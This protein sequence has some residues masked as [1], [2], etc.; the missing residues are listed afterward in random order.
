MWIS[1]W[2]SSD[3]ALQWHSCCQ[4]GGSWGPSSYQV[5]P[6]VIGLERVPQGLK[7]STSPP[8]GRRVS[9]P[10]LCSR[11]H[12]SPGWC[13]ARPGASPEQGRTPRMSPLPTVFSHQ[14]PVPSWLIYSFGEHQL[15]APFHPQQDGARE[16]KQKVDRGSS[17]AGSLCA[18]SLSTWVTGAH[19]AGEI[20][21]VK[22]KEGG[23]ASVSP[24][25][26]AEL[27]KL[28]PNGVHQ[29]L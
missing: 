18:R 26:K 12:T 24:L 11:A 6:A 21:R 19:L 16:E 14:P 1:R 23:K 29:L 9:H 15:N 10:R 17:Q 20:W 2:H 3:V 22:L 25:S 28:L 13:P 27:G 7:E 5:P 8:T 4:A